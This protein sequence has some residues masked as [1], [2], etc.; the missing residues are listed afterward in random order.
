MLGPLDPHIA[1]VPRKGHTKNGYTDPVQ[2]SAIPYMKSLVKY[3]LASIRMDSSRRSTAHTWSHGLDCRRAA[4]TGLD[5]HRQVFP[6]RWIEGL[7]KRTRASY[8][9][10]TQQIA[11]YNASKALVR[12]R[13]CF[14]IYKL[15]ISAAQLAC[16]Q[17]WCH[18]KSRRGIR[19]LYTTYMLNRSPELF[20][21]V[22][23]RPVD[24]VT[25]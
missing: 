6:D 4:N 21:L 23:H 12:E 18:S 16:T 20:I 25:A 10:G 17:F 3:P 1:I 2:S 11:S 19:E 24:Y 5:R 14:S 9:R 22:I 8:V 7:R 13:T 15:W